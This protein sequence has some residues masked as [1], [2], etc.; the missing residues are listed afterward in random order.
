MS[1]KEVDLNF[2]LYPVERSKDGVYS[3]IIGSGLSINELSS[4]YEW[5]EIEMTITNNTQNVYRFK[6]NNSNQ[7]QWRLKQ[8]NSYLHTGQFPD[9]KG[10]QEDA[11][12]DVPAWDG[13]SDEH[14]QK[15]TS[16]FISIPWVNIGD[17]IKD[18]SHYIKLELTVNASK[19]ISLEKRTVTVNNIT[20]LQTE[21][22]GEDEVYI[23]FNGNTKWGKHDINE[24]DDKDNPTVK[25]VKVSEDYISK[26]EIKIKEHDYGKDDSLL[27][28]TVH[29]GT[30]IGTAE[31]DQEHKG[32]HYKLSYTIS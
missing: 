11:Y 2:D 7:Y 22:N 18:G 23:N 19:A 3:R 20:C 32:A 6:I 8:E 4:K 1:D 21:E 28:F 16:R 10:S 5:Y 15:T 26:I 17:R 31:E 14:P 24:S 27:Y 9:A 25:D 29:Y 12:V 30:P 13:W